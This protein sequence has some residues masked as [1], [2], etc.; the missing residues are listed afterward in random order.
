M[1]RIVALGT[2][3]EDI[4]FEYDFS[5]SMAEMERKL[6]HLDKVVGGSVHNT[7]YYLALKNSEIQVVLCTLN[8]GNLVRNF[9]QRLNCSNYNVLMTKGELLQYPVSII[10]L[11]NNGEK[12]MLSFDPQTDDCSLIPL[13]KKETHDAELVYTSFYEI[14]ESNYLSIAEIFNYCTTH[15][16]KVMVDLCPLIRGIKEETIRLILLNTTII[17]GNE[18]EYKQLMKIMKCEDAQEILR[19]FPNIDSV[20]IKMGK[21]GAVAYIRDKQGSIIRQCQ[22]SNRTNDIKNTTGCGDIFNAVVISGICNGEN[23]SKILEFAVN[24]SS[25][26]AIGGLPW[27]Q[28]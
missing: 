12:Q 24:E 3:R 2:L 11:K 16:R 19:R 25:I 7:C 22:E 27:I 17:S 5:V 8:Y 14:N 26:I 9:R 28:E 15:G 21:N 13:F 1:K 23:N 18:H 10:G 20:Y 6:M 4:T